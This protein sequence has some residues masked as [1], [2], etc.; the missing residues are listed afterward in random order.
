MRKY[1]NKYTYI[2]VCIC[3]TFDTRVHAYTSA[4]HQFYIVKQFNKMFIDGEYV[5]MVFT[6]K[7]KYMA[8]HQLI[9]IPD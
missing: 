2:Y 7:Y 1:V 8:S 4:K 5:G 6:N 9:L 3:V